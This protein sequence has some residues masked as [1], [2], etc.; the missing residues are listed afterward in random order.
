MS[1]ASPFP[2]VRGIGWRLRDSGGPPSPV[3]GLGRLGCGARLLSRSPR[4]GWL[5]FSRSVAAP[6]QST[7]TRWCGRPRSARSP[8]DGR[9]SLRSPSSQAVGRQ[10]GP[11]RRRRTVRWPLRR[12][13]WS[14]ASTC[15]GPG[16]PRRHDWLQRRP[17]PRS[18]SS[19][20]PPR[21]RSRRGLCPGSTSP[22]RTGRTYAARPCT[23]ACRC[24]ST[25]PRPVTVP[26]PR[27]PPTTLAPGC[28]CAGT[29]RRG[30]R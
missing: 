3:D 23:P 25:A 2:A 8:R 4:S 1:C 24:T 16:R 17:A 11:C 20:P 7:R 6:G 5:R 19:S 14:P 13:H 9:F 30:R 26:G 18:P 27:C 12:S 22:P 28:G 10:W 29:R 21:T 15:C